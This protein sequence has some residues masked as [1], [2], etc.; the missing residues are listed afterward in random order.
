MSEYLATQPFLSPRNNRGLVGAVFVVVLVILTCH[1]EV[2]GQ[3]CTLCP[4]PTFEPPRVIDT[5]NLPTPTYAASIVSGDFNNDG[6]LDLAWSYGGGYVPG[7]IA[8]M[9]GDGTGNF[10]SPIY[11]DTTSGT[12]LVHA[13]TGDFNSDGNL[14]IAA[15]RL[16]GQEDALQVFLGDG[17]GHFTVTAYLSADAGQGGALAVGDLNNDNKLDIV[18]FVGESPGGVS[19]IHLGDGLG[20]FFH[21][22]TFGPLSA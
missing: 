22:S 9:L 10:G 19:F 3:G 14:D 18:V 15:L 6:K 2:L 1:C 21:P 20:G 17:T 4:L 8:I 5:T 11:I 7:G 16:N 12:P 13:V